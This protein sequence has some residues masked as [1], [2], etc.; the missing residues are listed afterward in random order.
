MALPEF[1]NSIFYAD[2][3]LALGYW[4]LA[5]FKCEGLFLRG[6]GEFDIDTYKGNWFFCGLRNNVEW[7]RNTKGGT[8]ID[9]SNDGL[10]SQK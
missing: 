3:L 7:P 1:P 2:C 5:A 4:P 10:V 9:G 8:P 6:R